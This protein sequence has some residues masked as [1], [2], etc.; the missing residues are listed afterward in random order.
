MWQGVTLQYYP[1]GKNLRLLPLAPRGC[2]TSTR[3]YEKPRCRVPWQSMDGGDF[4]DQKIV[5]TALIESNT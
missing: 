5:A 2:W 4:N 1:R 3:Q